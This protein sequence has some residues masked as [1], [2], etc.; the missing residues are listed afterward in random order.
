MWSVAVWHAISCHKFMQMIKIREN[1]STPTFGTFMLRK[2][3]PKLPTNLT[4]IFHSKSLGT[5]ANGCGYTATRITEVFPCFFLG[6]KANA[7]LKPAKMG[8]GQHS[9]KFV[10][11]VVFYSIVLLL[12][13]LLYVLF[14]CKLFV[15][16]F[17]YSIVLLLIVLLYV[18]CVCKCVLYHCHRVSTQLQLTNISYHIITRAACNFII[19]RHEKCCDL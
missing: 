11:C 3:Q 17:C 14:V 4:E 9:S 2:I 18:L 16:F 13:V 10:V 12:I 19:Q 5:T 6:C 1:I 8:H 7:K 15:L